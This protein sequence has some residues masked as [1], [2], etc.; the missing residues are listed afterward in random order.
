MVPGLAWKSSVRCEL[1]L[2]YGVR[3]RPSVTQ[4]F[5]SHVSVQFSRPHAPPSLSLPTVRGGVG[6]FLGSALRSL[7][8]WVFPSQHRR[9][10]GHRRLMGRRGPPTPSSRGFFASQGLRGP[11]ETL[12]C[13]VLV[14]RRSPPCSSSFLCRRRGVPSRLRTPGRERGPGPARLLQDGMGDR[15]RPRSSKAFVGPASSWT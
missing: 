3:R 2:A 1:A 15:G 5:V 13:V 9:A 4:L 6:L 12:G 8:A 11:T 10:R 14:L 7:D